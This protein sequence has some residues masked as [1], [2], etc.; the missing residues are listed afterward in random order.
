MK[1]KATTTKKKITFNK[2]KLVA[3]KVIK[4]TTNTAKSRSVKS[5]IAHGWKNTNTQFR[6]LTT[7]VIVVLL[8]QWITSGLSQYMG[9]EM[10][11][12]SDAWYRPIDFLGAIIGMWIGL[13]FTDI[14]IHTTQNRSW[15]IT[16][17]FPN[18]QLLGRYI[19]AYFLMG[20]SIL[21]WFI[22]LIVPGIIIAY[23]LS[24][25]QYYM[26]DQHSGAIE[27]LKQSRYATKWQVRK[28]IGLSLLFVIINILWLLAL[29]IG[30]LWTIPTTIIAYAYVYERLK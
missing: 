6:K 29:W 16:N 28:L 25:T 22:L 10:W 26:I 24:L 12:W 13:W 4:Q 8:I 11:F 5:A 18:I 14:A 3:K 27:A 1:S 19:I 20:V 2:K 17:L 9:I 30:L 7:V 21:I 23:R 15:K